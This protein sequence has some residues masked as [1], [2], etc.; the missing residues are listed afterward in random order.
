MKRTKYLTL[1]AITIASVALPTKAANQ[2]TL[3]EDLRLLEWMVGH[4]EGRLT[5]EKNEPVKWRME[6]KADLGGTVLICRW[7]YPHNEEPWMSPG[8]SI[9]YWQKEANSLADFGTDSRGEHFSDLVTNL[10]E[11]GF[12][13]RGYDYK[14][15]FTPRLIEI[16]KIDENHFVTTF[17]RQISAEE[18]TLDGKLFS[19]RVGG[20]ESG[21]LSQ[22]VGVL[23]KVA[24]GALVCAGAG[25]V[26]WWVVRRKNGRRSKP[27]S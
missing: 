21:L 2:P 26:T 25:L 7:H 3:N 10:T 18:A 14:G 4:W 24:I 1:F 22:A 15:N 8:F 9:Y 5:D 13:L 11:S 17:R 6:A 19:T 12:T 20:F 16:S 27:A 23:W